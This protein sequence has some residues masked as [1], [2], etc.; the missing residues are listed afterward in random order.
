MT[1]ANALNNSVDE[2]K[3]G[4]EVLAEAKYLLAGGFYLGAVSRAYYA[5]YHW[6][7]ALLVSRGIEPKTHRGIIQLLHLHFIKEGLLD[8]SVVA[9]LA[10]LATYRELSDYTSTT[11]FT[12]KQARNEILRATAFI[13]ASRS[14]L[15]TTMAAANKR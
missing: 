5:A 13:K 3:R 6:A 11:S 1:G 14:L 9:N 2:I 7:R 4:D 12:K 15:K 8:E 10:H